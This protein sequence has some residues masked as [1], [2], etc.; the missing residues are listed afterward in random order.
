LFPRGKKKRKKATV[1]WG[2]QREKKQQFAHKNK[3]NKTGWSAALTVSVS[4]IFLIVEC[5]F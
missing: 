4:N 2:W 5:R 3:A 1:K